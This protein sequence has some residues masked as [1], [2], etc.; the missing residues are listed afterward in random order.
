[1][2]NHGNNAHLLVVV[3]EK[4]QLDK[5]SMREFLQT[6]ADFTD[7]EDCFR[8]DTIELGYEDEAQRVSEE[9]WYKHKKITNDAKRLEKM[10][11]SLFEV[12][13]FIGTSDLYGDYTYEITDV[14]KAF[15]VSIAYVQ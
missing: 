6:D 13:Y 2:S 9:I 11:K 10:M 15:V 14:G 5:D 4:G 3:L 1:M 8:S 7:N 12:P